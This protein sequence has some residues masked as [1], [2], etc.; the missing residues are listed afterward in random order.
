[1]SAK[2]TNFL[3]ESIINSMWPQFMTTA[4]G[5]GSQLT[6]EERQSVIQRLQKHHQTNILKA[7]E[8]ATE[9]QQ[10]AILR[11]MKFFDLDAFDGYMA[12]FWKNEHLISDISNVHNIPDEFIVR[13]NSIDASTKN[14]MTEDGLKAVARGEGG[15]NSRSHITGCRRWQTTRL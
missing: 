3:L 14:E 9:S 15:L 6:D 10:E 11:E 4:K 7:L 12:A 8:Q 5:S 2:L 1:M 13:K